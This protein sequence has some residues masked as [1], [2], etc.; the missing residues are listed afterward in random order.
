MNFQCGHVTSEFNGGEVKV[1]NLRQICS[2]YNGSMGT[3]NMDEYIIKHGLHDDI[4]IKKIVNPKK[5]NVK[6][7]KSHTNCKVGKSPAT[8]Q[9]EWGIFNLCSI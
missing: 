4:K 3:M 9:W 6:K 1:P 8:L 7:L 2:L 5:K